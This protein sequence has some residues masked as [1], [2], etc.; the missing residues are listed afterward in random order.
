MSDKWLELED[1]KEIG[2]WI[3]AASILLFLLGFALSGVMIVLGFA[4]RLFI[5]A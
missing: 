5:W 3:V 2:R 1:A 4:W